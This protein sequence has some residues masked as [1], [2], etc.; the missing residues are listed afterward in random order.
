MNTEGN[1]LQRAF[2]KVSQ[3][4]AAV[5]RLLVRGYQL[6]ISPWLGQRCRHEPSCSNYALEALQTHGPIK[7]LWLTVWR[8]LR[9]N[10]WQGGGYDPVPPP[11]NPKN[12][13]KT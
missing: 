6:F 7:G 12:Q 5:L 11:K 13:S 4:V 8:I 9:C 1:L 10:P 3:G 2:A